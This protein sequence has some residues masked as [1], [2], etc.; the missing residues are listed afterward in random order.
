MRRGK[1]GLIYTELPQDLQPI[2]RTRMIETIQR[3]SSDSFLSNEATYHSFMMSNQHLSTG[4]LEDIKAPCPIPT[5]LAYQASPS[6]SEN[7]LAPPTRQLSFLG[8]SLGA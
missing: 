1:R 2:D 8:Q 6:P 5:F 7:G 4:I 3:R